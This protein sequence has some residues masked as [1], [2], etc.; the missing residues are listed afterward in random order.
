MPDRPHA[1]R[2]PATP[3]PRVAGL[4]RRRPA[5]ADSV[6]EASAPTQPAPTARSGAAAA[7][8][9][10]V[11]RWPLPALL[12]WLAAVAMS[13]GVQA[14]GLG[15]AAGFAAGTALGVLGSLLGRSR[16]QRLVIA[17]GYPAAV[18]V[19]G[20]AAG[21]PVWA[22]LVPLA[23]LLL[24]YPLRTWRDAPLFPTPPSALDGLAAV[25]PLAG[26]RVRG[27]A[28]VL[29]AGCGLG[30]GLRALRRA[31]P[32]AA[33]E[34]VEWSWPLRLLCAWRCRWARV[35]QGDLWR[36]DWS[37]YDLVYLF[38]R[39]ESMPRVVDK[40]RREMRAGAWLV[41]LD[42]EAPGLEPSAT[43]LAPSGQRVWVYRP[44]IDLASA[45]RLRPRPRARA[46]PDVFGHSVLDV[47][48]LDTRPAAG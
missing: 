41:S 37:A 31:Y 32:Q 47:E 39:P 1:P 46:V 4:G 13:Q 23:A 12:V 15:A 2:R 45:R 29:D 18:A 25:A 36:D 9:R 35:R 43:L 44:G 27:A 28:R 8:A 42:F 5:A 6:L 20:A 30:D 48:P 24:L 10:P 7:G 22:W 3:H 21:L 33:V 11:L 34:G 26:D 40:A 14:A 16:V 38:Q 17:A 19:L